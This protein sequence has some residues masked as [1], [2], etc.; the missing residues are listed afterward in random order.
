LKREKV[1]KELCKEVVKW[2]LGETGSKFRHGSDK[3]TPQVA[4]F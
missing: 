2:K 4:G 1:V 3:K